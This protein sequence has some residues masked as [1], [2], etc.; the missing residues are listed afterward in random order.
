MAITPYREEDF[1]SSDG[2]EYIPDDD[3]DDDY[4]SDFD[5]APSSDFRWYVGEYHDSDPW[6]P[7]DSDS[8]WNDREEDVELCDDFCDEMDELEVEWL[9]SDGNI[10][11]ECSE[12]EG[13]Y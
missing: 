3:D 10:D 2:G 1:E 11:L 12:D 6:C 5:G 13:L 9:P 4:S 7:E 8:H